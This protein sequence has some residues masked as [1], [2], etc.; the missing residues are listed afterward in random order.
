MLA[1]LFYPA[2]RVAL[3]GLPATVQQQ[4]PV[5]PADMAEPTQKLRR[6]CKLAR[7]KVEVVNRRGHGKGTARDAWTKETLWRHIASRVSLGATP[8]ELRE[9]PAR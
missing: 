3:G 2:D 7:S 1:R 8:I 5:G 4:L 6:K 9:L